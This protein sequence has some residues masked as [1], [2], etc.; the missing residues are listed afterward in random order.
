MKRIIGRE[1]PDLVL[2]TGMQ[3]MSTLGGLPYNLSVNGPENISG[4]GIYILKI[5]SSDMSETSALVYCFDSHTGFDPVTDLDNYKWILYDQVDW[6]RKQ[7]NIFTK[8]NGGEP[9]PSMAFFHIPLPKY[10]EI[11]GEVSTTG[12]I[13]EVVC[14]PD[15]NSGLFSAMIESGDVMGYLQDTIITTT[16][17]ALYTIY[18]WHMTMLPAD[19]VM[20]I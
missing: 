4:N 6:Y 14:S 9:K 12:V 19:N 11:I 8:E 15:I 3:I 2:L 16:L 17:L 10:N 18:A 5:Q 7:S 1:N 13:K 20:S